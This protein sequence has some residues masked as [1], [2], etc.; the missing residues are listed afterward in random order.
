MTNKYLCSFF[1]R[2]IP[3]NKYQINKMIREKDQFND[4]KAINKHILIKLSVGWKR[5][6][7]VY[8]GICSDIEYQWKMICKNMF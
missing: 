1:L 3:E 2:N 7:I 4:L 8:N 6:S 5:Q